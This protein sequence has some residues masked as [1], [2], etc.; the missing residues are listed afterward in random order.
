MLT[1][2]FTH[3]TRLHNKRTNRTKTTRNDQQKNPKKNTR[4]VEPV[5]CFDQLMWMPL[6]R[7]DCAASDQRTPCSDF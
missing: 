5:Q 4:S 7:L 1:S 2:I 6:E 3:V